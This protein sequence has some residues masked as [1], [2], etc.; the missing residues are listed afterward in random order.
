MEQLFLNTIKTSIISSIIIL[1]VVIITPFT[2]KR[3]SNRWRYWLWVILCIM[4]IL[5]IDISTH[6]API[7][8]NSQNIK[9]DRKVILNKGNIK[10]DEI[11]KS[12]IHQQSVT[13]K[14][15]N[16]LTTIQ[17]IMLIWAVGG[18]IFLLWNIVSYFVY[19]K[20]INR[21]SYKVKDHNINILF[22]NIKNELKIK[23]NVQLKICANINSPM[24]IGLFK[25]TI[26]LPKNRFTKIELKNILLHELTHFKRFDLEFKMFILIAK[27][28][29]WFNPFVHLMSKIVS[30]DI[31]LCCD[32]DVTENKSIDYKKIY[33]QT[34]ISSM[35]LNKNNSVEISTNFNGG[36]KIMK[37]RIRKL[38]EHKKQRSGKVILIFMLIIV[39]L[40]H[41][42]VAC[43]DSNKYNNKDL[44]IGYINF[45]N[46]ILYLDEVELIT[47]E[48]KDRIKELELNKQSDM[49]CGRYIYNESSD[50]IPFKLNEK[51]VYNFVDWRNDFISEG[52]DNNY[53]TTNKDEFINHLNT[54]PCYLESNLDDKTVYD[55]INYW[56]D[57][58]R[59]FSTTNKDGLFKYLSNCL[60]EVPK[61]PFWIE[62]EGNSIISITEF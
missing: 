37:E 22:N 38:I 53:S 42:L 59:Q 54:Y 15:N 34:I 62:T 1:L 10:T 18:T 45:D 48:N 3:Y 27:S 26:L 21:W 17:F 47:Y 4:L 56:G 9:S 51:T 29:H 11:S 14:H 39:L 24:L 49:F 41:V 35:K 50:T 46:D 30:N 12:I 44:H 55:I 2:K 20:S 36:K 33:I 7:K 40:T 13:K 25:P 28:I 52:K 58:D 16:S 60:N 23:S 32:A 31:E 6:D 43:N 19:K 8:I 5:P 57:N 61:V